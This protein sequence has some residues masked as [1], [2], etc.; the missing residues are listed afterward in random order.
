MK[1]IKSILYFLAVV[2]TGF[3][4]ACSDS[5]EYVAGGENGMGVYFPASLSSEVHVTKSQAGLEIPV[6][7]TQ[8]SEAISI[9]VSGMC[10][11]APTIFT[12]PDQISFA[13]GEG[14]KMLVIGIDQSQLKE[15]T[16]YY[17]FL[18]LGDSDNTSNYGLD[19]YE[20]TLTLP[21]PWTS[22]GKAT[23][24]DGILATLVGWPVP[25]IEVEIEESGRTKGLFRLHNP[26]GEAYA[27]A[28]EELLGDAWAS[29]AGTYTETVIEIDASDANAVVIPS[30]AIGRTLIPFGNPVIGTVQPGKLENGVITFPVKGLSIQIPES[31]NAGNYYANATGEFYVALPGAILLKPSVSV[32][33]NGTYLDKRGNSS[34]ILEFTPNEDVQKIYYTVVTGNITKDES[35]LAAQAKGMVDGTNK[36]TK[37]IETKGA[38]DM[39]NELYAL[40]VSGQYTVVAVPVGMEEGQ[41]IQGP[42]VGYVFN[43]VAGGEKPATMPLEEGYYKFSTGK[44]EQGKEYF[45]TIVVSQIEGNEYKVENL[46]EYPGF[47]YATYDDVE[48]TL[49][50]DGRANLPTETGTQD[51]DDFFGN[52][53]FVFNEEQTMVSGIFCFNEEVKDALPETMA[54]WIIHVDPATG[55]L[56]ET[57]NY[58]Y[59]I[60]ANLEGDKITTL[61][62]FANITVS[63]TVMEKT[64]EAPK[65]NS[66]LHASR[67]P[68]PLAMNFSSFRRVLAP[69]RF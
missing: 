63:G 54:P 57:E 56:S 10:P 50:L 65:T 61:A 16:G 37:I 60:V 1:T 39:V 51:F 26:Y 35:A 47:C 3:I 44:D 12:F 66:V 21:G 30:Q 38:T 6:M 53:Y 18:S 43:F 32:T 17:I 55:Y 68:A 27:A 67:M 34:A 25:T 19:V 5:D 69:H 31:E 13:A 7:R 45:N 11:T 23:F 29:A 36:N 46:Y 42:T 59:D 62:G 58:L 15:D 22:L 64:N 41:T 40:E 33:Y 14:E 8:T 48:G 4:T 20:F 28:M 9:D 24:S 2:A 52:F 49:T